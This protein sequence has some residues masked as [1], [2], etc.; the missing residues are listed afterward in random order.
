[1]GR[2]SSSAKIDDGRGAGDAARD[3]GHAPTPLREAQLPLRDERRTAQ[4][5]RAQLLGAEQDEVRDA[6]DRRGG[7]GTRRDQAFPSGQGPAGGSGG[8]RAGGADREQATGHLTAGDNHHEPEA[9]SASDA[10]YAGVR[11]FLGGHEAA[12]L[13]HEEL[14][15]RL[16][17]DARELV[18]Q[19]Y[20]DHLD[21]RATRETRAAQVVDSDRVAHRAVEAGHQR[22][23]M[24]IFG[25]VSVTRLAYRAKGQENLHLADAAL[26]LPEEI[27]SHGLRELAAIE[28]TRGSYEEAQAAIER[29]TG[30]KLGKRQLEELA[31]AAARHVPIVVDF[32]HVLQYLSAPRGA[33]T[34]PLLE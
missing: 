5:G 23:L 26:N 30:V 27:H 1:M 25:S 33:L 14:E 22:P 20:Q 34:Y 9:F 8:Q 18:R 17:V 11:G 28:A 31:A 4:L 19:L 6:E 21:L 32:I 13:T 29:G 2:A 15:A 24:T 10:L 12:G 3:G 7:S 16:N